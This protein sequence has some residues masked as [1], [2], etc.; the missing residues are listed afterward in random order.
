MNSVTFSINTRLTSMVSWS[1]S[2][3]RQHSNSSL[4]ISIS[5]LFCTKFHF[6]HD[7]FCFFS[8]ICRKE[9]EGGRVFRVPA[10]ERPQPHDDPSLLQASRELPRHRTHGEGFPFWKKS[11]SRNS[12]L[13]K[14]SNVCHSSFC[15]CSSGFFLRKLCVVQY[16]MLYI[17]S[18]H[19]LWHGGVV[20]N[21]CL[22]N[23]LMS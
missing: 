14:G 18:V 10:S 3:K 19:F 17:V 23:S 4:I 15:Y 11:W 2:L 1:Q 7:H 16:N 6:I 5:L 13:L 8:R 21:I 20:G 22:P 9:L 12:G